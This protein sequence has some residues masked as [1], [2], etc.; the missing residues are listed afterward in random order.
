MNAN[1]NQPG[2]GKYD[3]STLP[4]DVDLEVGRVDLTNM[5]SFHEYAGNEMLLYKQY[6]DK[7]HNFRFAAFRLA[8]RGLIDDNFGG[9]HKAYSASGWRNFSSL[10]GASNVISADYFSTLSKKD[11][12]WS[13]AAG[14]GSYVSAQGVGN[15]LFFANHDVKT[16]FTMLF[17]SYFGDWNN[18]DNFLRA[19]LCSKSYV[20]TSC[21]AGMPQWFVHHMGIGKTI[22]Y[23]TRVSQNNDASGSYVPEGDRGIRGVHVA[24]MGDPTLRMLNVVPP[25]NLVV[26]NSGRDV[27]LNWTASTDD[28]L[29]YHVY[30]SDN[31]SGPFRRLTE[32]PIS[33]TRHADIG[34]LPGN[35]T[36]MVKS[37]KLEQGTGSYYNASVGIMGSN[38]AIAI[39]TPPAPQPLPVSVRPEP[40]SGPN[41]ALGAKITASSSHENW[42]EQRAVDGDMH[43]AFETTYEKYPIWFTLDLGAVHPITRVEITWGNWDQAS[44]GS[45]AST[46]YTLSVS[47]D[48]QNWKVA[49]TKKHGMGGKEVI[50]LAAEARYIRLDSTEH[51]ARY[52]AVCEFEVFGSGDKN[53]SNKTTTESAQ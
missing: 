31:P 26:L 29:G 13:Y 30:R 37:I 10:F 50:P 46:E 33:Q 40:V 1:N 34:A 18:R 3:Q 2:D 45:P 27:M 16:V 6:L 43:T 48:G 42:P 51:G 52:I 25:S 8:N 24:M 28:I 15:S 14:G 41:L 35:Y 36:Y 7:D 5:E 20:L 9:D 23:V 4:S 38:Y 22:G 21:W 17:G 19:A 11:Y 12:L 53:R 39:A 32:N 49:Y 44:Y 47:D